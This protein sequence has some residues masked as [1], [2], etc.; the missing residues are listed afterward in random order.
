MKYFNKTFL[1]TCKIEVALAKA[2]GDKDTPRPWS[3]YSKGSSVSMIKDNKEKETLLMTGDLKQ[4]ED[5]K[6]E[7]AQRL[8]QDLHKSRLASYLG[9]LYELEADP[10]FTE[11]MSLHK[12]KTTTRAWTNDDLPGE[13]VPG[14]RKR[15]EGQE[16]SE[17]KTKVRPSLVS[18]EARRPGG[19]GIL[20]TRTHLRFDEDEEN[21]KERLIHADKGKA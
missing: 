1:D 15:G 2:V 18:V 8:N 19:K 4:D 16:K 17:K 6:K 7:C 5:L 3:R 11:F 21:N 9:E 14:K 20:L 13:R 12:S 10:E